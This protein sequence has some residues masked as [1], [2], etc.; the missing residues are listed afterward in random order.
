M[1]PTRPS[2]ASAERS[3]WAFASSGAECCYG[4]RLS[5][6]NPQTARRGSGCKS[7][8]PSEAIPCSSQLPRDGHLR[9]PAPLTRFGNH[10]IAIAPPACRLPAVRF[11]AAS[12][13][14]ERAEATPTRIDDDDRSRAALCLHRG[15]RG[16]SGRLSRL[17]ENQ[18]RH[19][20]A[21]PKVRSATQDRDL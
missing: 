7:I 21:L 12:H 19:C 10:E 8:F 14:A 3:L 1:L 4:R 9:G 6:L 20:A 18:I 15:S 2:P 17:R 16:H 13:A 11:P 5:V